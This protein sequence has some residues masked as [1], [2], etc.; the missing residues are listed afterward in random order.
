MNFFL[1]FAAVLV[2]LC[3]WYALTVGG[4][5]AILASYG[6]ADLL[7]LLLPTVLGL[8]AAEL[9]IRRARKPLAGNF[10]D[11]YAAMAATVWIGGMLC[12]VALAWGGVLHDQ[13]L[14]LVGTI[15]FGAVAS[16]WGVICGGVLGIGEGL[17]LGLPLA[18]ALGWFGEKAGSVPTARGVFE[19]VRTSRDG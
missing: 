14:G 16:L 7:A 5:P 19:R 17:M 9:T 1:R 6:W 18:V 11:R 3:N 13:A 8:V 12:G 4:S 10:L 15:G 2:A